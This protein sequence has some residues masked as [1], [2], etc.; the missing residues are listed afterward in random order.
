M[1]SA[2]KESGTAIQTWVTASF[3]GNPVEQ[4]H[5]LFLKSGVFGKR[6][7]QP[8][9]NV[10]LVIVSHIESPISG[11]CSVQTHGHYG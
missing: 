2:A 10:D 9:S 11:R 3:P 8:V 7:E 1:L 6:I 5:N 4:T